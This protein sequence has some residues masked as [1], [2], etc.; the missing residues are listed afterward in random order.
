MPRPLY[1]QR[2][3]ALMLGAGA[4]LATGPN[5]TPIRYEMA[6]LSRVFIIYLL[7]VIDTKRTN[8]ASRYI[9]RPARP[10]TSRFVSSSSSHLLLSYLNPSSRFLTIIGEGHVFHHRR[11]RLAVSSLLAPLPGNGSCCLSVKEER[12]GPPSYGCAA[13]PRHKRADLWS[14]TGCNSQPVYSRRLR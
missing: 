7:N 11:L 14:D 9:S 6:Q 12:P 3:G 5:L 1:G 10:F 4:R 13:C 8:L 2:Q